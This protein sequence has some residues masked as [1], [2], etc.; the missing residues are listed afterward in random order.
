MTF[1]ILT[2]D[3]TC[4]LLCSQ[5]RPA[6]NPIRPN[7]R[8]TNT[9]DGERYEQ[10]KDNDGDDNNETKT[11][12]IHTP[13]DSS[14]TNKIKDDSQPESIPVIDTLDLVDLERLLGRTFLKQKDKD[15][16]IHQARIVE[17]IQHQEEYKLLTFRKEFRTRTYRTYVWTQVT[18]THTYH[19]YGRRG[20]R[21]IRPHYTIAAILVMTIS[22]QRTN[23]PV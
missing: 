5:V 18:L 4:V 2:K 1:K 11:K 19:T 13:K 6:D 8:L 22:R 17:A 21:L 3:H 7:L 23:F 16:N 20:P 10:S 9:L 15:G 14:E 12:V